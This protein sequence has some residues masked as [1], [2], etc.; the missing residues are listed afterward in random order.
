MCEGEGQRESFVHL[1]L[2]DSFKEIKT[3]YDPTL[4]PKKRKFHQVFQSFHFLWKIS[5]I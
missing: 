3:I 2:S 5:S 1:L 4:T